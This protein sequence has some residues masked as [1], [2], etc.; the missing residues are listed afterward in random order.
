MRIR[1]LLITLSLF[2]TT[3]AMAQSDTKKSDTGKTASES[4]SDKSDKS[5]KGEQGKG[6][7]YTKDH[8]KPAQKPP[9][10]G[11]ISNDNLKSAAPPKSDSS[12]QVFTN[13]SL[14]ERYGQPD[15][16]P[17]A[18]KAEAPSPDADSEGASN[19]DADADPNADAPAEPELS[20]QERTERIQELEAKIERLEKRKL[21]IKNPLLAG[22]VPPTEEERTAER[23][24]ANPDRL[25]GVEAQIEELKAELQ[26]LRDGA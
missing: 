17:P 18:P 13:D 2:C 5:S 15:P 8:L 9:T 19:A 6:T 21:A 24:M 3:G 10:S 4:K 12:V 11:V 22:T 16:A 25:A 23:G 14:I 1:V 26:E 20:P 7:V